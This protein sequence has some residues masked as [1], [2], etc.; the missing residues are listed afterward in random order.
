MRSHRSRLAC[1]DSPPGPDTAGGSTSSG[2]PAGSVSGATPTAASG[3]LLRGSSCAAN[4]LDRVAS[5]SGDAIGKLAATASDG[6]R[7]WALAS[8]SADSVISAHQALAARHSTPAHTIAKCRRVMV[9]TL[10][11]SLSTPGEQ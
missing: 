2:A 9:L 10:V 8:A 7:K 4:D 6:P 3:R 1:G 5:V 11:G